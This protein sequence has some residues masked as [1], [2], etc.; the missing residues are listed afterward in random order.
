MARSGGKSAVE[1]MRKDITITVTGFASGLSAFTIEY[2][3]R[4]R[5]QVAQVANQLAASFIEW[6]EKNSEQQ[7]E[8]TTEFIRPLSLR[9]RNR[10]WKNRKPD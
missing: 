1:L 10:I 9:K 2:E 3:G 8:D 4:Q 5:Q 6:N 7:A